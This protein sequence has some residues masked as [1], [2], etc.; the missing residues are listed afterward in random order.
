MR[1]S[2]TPFAVSAINSTGSTESDSRSVTI[3]GTPAAPDSFR[4]IAGDG[5]VW[6]G[7][8]SPA[9]F[10]ISGYEYRQKEGTDAFG[11]WQA[12]PGSRAGAPSTS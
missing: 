5:Q 10:T 4:A 11:D 8:R 12:I 9:D 7:W 3:V 2:R 1:A 6:L